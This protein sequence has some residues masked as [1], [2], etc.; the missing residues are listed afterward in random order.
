MSV[1]VHDVVYVYALMT[2]DVVWYVGRTDCP[3][4]RA[5]KHRSLNKYNKCGSKYISK[6]YQW[7]MVILQKCKDSEGLKLEQYYYDSLNPFYN[8]RRPWQ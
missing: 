4:W 2:D 6:E 7:K 1:Y 3:T 5:S 8:C